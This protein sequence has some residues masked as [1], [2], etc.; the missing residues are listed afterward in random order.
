MAGELYALSSALVEYIAT[1]PE[2]A[3]QARGKEDKQVCRNFTFTFESYLIS[4][5]QTAKWIRMHPRAGEVR[6]KNERCWIYDHPRANTVYS[7]G[8]LFP[9]EAQRVRHETTHGLTPAQIH[10]LPTST[11]TSDPSLTHSTVSRFGVRYVPPSTNLTTEQEVEALIEGSPLSRLRDETIGG[12]EGAATPEEVRRAWRRRELRQKRFPEGAKVG[13]T[14]VVHYIK[15]HEW[16]LETALAF[17]GGEDEEG[18]VDV[19][20]EIEEEQRKDVSDLEWIAKGASGGSS[21]SSSS[22]SKTTQGRPNR[23]ETDLSNKSPLD[24][25]HLDVDEEPAS[26]VAD[27]P[28]A[29]TEAG[30]ENP[31]LPEDV[32]NDDVV[33]APIEQD[34]QPVDD[35]VVVDAPEDNMDE[36]PTE[37]EEIFPVM[38]SQVPMAAEQF[39]AVEG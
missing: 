12:S 25:S 31:T 14:I 5:Y 21:S 2:L 33:A 22:K 24:L 4:S 29:E 36:K 3:L 27:V 7:H 28:T 20:G 23:Y 16:Y 11:S 8:F 9:S 30:N 37:Q 17:L 26:P 19:I 38:E 39:G 10:L 35:S 34:E 1:T 13:G 18:P 6:W 32:G 15:S